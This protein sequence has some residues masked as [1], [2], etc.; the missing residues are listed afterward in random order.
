MFALLESRMLF[1]F[2]DSHADHN[3]RGLPVEHLNLQQPSITMHRVGRDGTLINFRSEFCSPENI[4]LICYGEVDCRCHIGKQVAAGRE[5]AEICDTLVAGFEQT[6]SGQILVARKIIV[7]SITPSIRKDE[8]ESVHGP[9]T[10]EFPF[11]GSDED[12]VMY[13]RA[14]NDRLEEMCARHGWTFLNVWSEYARADGTLQY[15]RSDGVCHIRDNS[16]VIE[17]LLKVLD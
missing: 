3:F 10:H 7:C 2:G 15:E 17:A 8:Y 9:V 13:T 12:R 14:V 5:M 1:I 4:F 11:L 16:A 6:I